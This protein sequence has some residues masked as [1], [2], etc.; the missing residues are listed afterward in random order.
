MSAAAASLQELAWLTLN[1][2]C[3]DYGPATKLIPTLEKETDPDTLIITVDDDKNVAYPP[4]FV[5]AL[6]RQHL[7][8]PYIAF[9]NAGEMI[10]I[11]HFPSSGV[12][13]RSVSHDDEWEQ[14]VAVDILQGF[15]GAIYRRDF[16]SFESIKII[17]N[18]CF[19]AEDVWISAELARKGITRVRIPCT[20]SNTWQTDA[21]V[22]DKPPGAN[23]YL[24]G[25][26]KKD[27]CAAE[28][29]PYFQK[30]WRQTE[31]RIP[32]GFEWLDYLSQRS[33]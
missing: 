24:V 9:A 28:L 31:Q 33:E 8:A 7:K 6:L 19:W 22:A 11:D 29:L 13:V 16:F 15:Q 26:P 10:E 1:T 18:D 21:I 2:D 30:S 32:M 5:E 25:K 23:N 14:L 12:R 4:N 27:R 17:P 20:P 3:E